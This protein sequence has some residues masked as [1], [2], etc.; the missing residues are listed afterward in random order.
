MEDGKS[1][2][3]ILFAASRMQDLRSYLRRFTQV[4]LQQFI[5]LINVEEIFPLNWSAW[6]NDRILEII[7]FEC[8]EKE[9]LIVQEVVSNVF[10]EMDCIME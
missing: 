6:Y 3:N 7:N 5:L 1:G 8:W 9:T 4:W 2:R 10:C